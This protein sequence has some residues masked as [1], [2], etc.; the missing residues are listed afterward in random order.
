MPKY[1]KQWWEDAKQFKAKFIELPDIERM[2]LKCKDNDEKCYLL[3]LYYTG[4]RPSEL[5]MMG[6]KDVI[7]DEEFVKLQIPTLKGGIG[8]TIHLE[9]SDPNVSFILEH[10]KTVEERLI[11]KWKYYWETKNFI[12]RISNN[13]LTQYFFRHNRFSK[14]S[15]RGA[16]RNDLKYLKGAKDVRS[17][18]A[19]IHVGGQ[20]TKKLAKIID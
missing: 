11:S 20:E 10:S 3:L 19:Y 15:Q 5:L 13:Q 4:A 16:T 18:E 17:V 2:V 7:E 9:K 14:L 8:R 12:Y 1:K 6:K